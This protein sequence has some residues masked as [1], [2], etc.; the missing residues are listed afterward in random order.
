MPST[1]VALDRDYNIR[2]ALPS[3][4]RGI[5]SIFFEVR[6]LATSELTIVPREIVHQLA[7]SAEPTF[8]RCFS[9][10]FFI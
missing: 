5:I 8:R 2:L 1:T 10:I 6:T 7:N 4:R 9:G 3:R